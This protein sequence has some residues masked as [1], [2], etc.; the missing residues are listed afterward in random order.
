[1]KLR[2]A[3]LE[4]LC[5]LRARLKTTGGAL[6]PLHPRATFVSAKVAKASLPRKAR[7]QTTPVPRVSGRPQEVRIRDI[8][9]P[10]AHVRDPSRTL[11]G[12]TSAFPR[13]SLAY[14]AGEATELK[15]WMQLGPVWRGRVQGCCCAGITAGHG[16]MGV[17]VLSLVP[18]FARAKK[19]TRP[20]GAGARS[21][22][23]PEAT[24]N[25]LERGRSNPA[26]SFSGAPKGRTRL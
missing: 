20:A 14:G 8:S 17:N 5:A 6:R 15:P 21:N 12:S 24:Q 13:R 11:S 1:M 7:R 16:Q 26:I 3:R 10:D 22:T 19:G 2:S 18:F 25:Y 4:V 9:I 23:S